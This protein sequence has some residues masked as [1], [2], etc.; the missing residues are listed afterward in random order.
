M[1]QNPPVNL[2]KVRKTKARAAA[3]VKA[4]QNAVRFGQ[5]KSVTKLATAN[6][7]QATRL[8]DGHQRGDK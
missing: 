1:T 4:D 7:E 3:K 6:A 5:P 8:L 2:N